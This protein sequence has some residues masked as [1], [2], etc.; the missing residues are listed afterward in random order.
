MNENRTVTCPTQGCE[1]EGVAITLEDDIGAAVQCGVCGMLLAAQ[2]QW[3]EPPEPEPDEPADAVAE[4]LAR[5]A[6]LSPE[7]LTRLAT[8]I[9]ETGA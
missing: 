6:A 4:L 8:L 1:N 2:A 7:D 9:G 3:Y 5:I